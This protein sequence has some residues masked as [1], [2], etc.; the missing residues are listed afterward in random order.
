MYYNDLMRK[1]EENYKECMDY[2]KV[3]KIVFIIQTQRLIL[4]YL[5]YIDNKINKQ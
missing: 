5:I 3:D 4:D 2:Q 1:Y